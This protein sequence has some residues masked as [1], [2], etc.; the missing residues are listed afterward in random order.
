MKLIGMLGHGEYKPLLGPR[1]LPSQSASLIAMVKSAVQSVR[2][3]SEVRMHHDTL[4]LFLSLWVL[5][6]FARY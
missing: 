3:Y 4:F 2:S 6:D 5:S 1:A